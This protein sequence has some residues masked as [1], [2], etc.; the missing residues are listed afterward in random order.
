MHERSRRIRITGLACRLSAAA[1]G[2]LIAGVPV[3]AADDLLQQAHAAAGRVWY[4][5]YCTP[6]HGPGGGPGSAVY[7]VGDKPVDLRRYVAGH[8]GQ[9]PAHEWIAVVEHVDL[10]SPHAD[11]WEQMRTAQ[12]G[13]SAQGAAARGIVVLIADYIISVQTK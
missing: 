3:A 8:Q 1:I 11:V 6:C 5:K 7:R 4:D 2:L 9:F 13:T 10:T 12:A